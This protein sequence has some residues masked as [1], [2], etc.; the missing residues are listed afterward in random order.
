[1][2][3]NFIDN[4]K[5][6]TVLDE[7]AVLAM[8][9]RMIMEFEIRSFLKWCFE[10]YGEQAKFKHNGII[11]KF[12]AVNDLGYVTGIDDEGKEVHIHPRKVITKLPTKAFRFFQEEWLSS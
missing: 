7:T 1:M 2:K 5:D 9:A 11:H 12:I 10:E 4:L 6:S 8:T 3:Q